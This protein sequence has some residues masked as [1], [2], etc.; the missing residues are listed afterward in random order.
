LDMLNAPDEGHECPKC[1]TEYSLDL[2][3][4]CPRCGWAPL[5]QHRYDED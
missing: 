2:H 3:S 4:R 5:I 1:G